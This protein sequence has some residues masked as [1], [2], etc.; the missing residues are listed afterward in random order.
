MQSK[1]NLPESHPLFRVVEALDSAQEIGQGVLRVS[2]DE[3][4]ENPGS[5]ER[6]LGAPALL[7]KVSPGRSAAVGQEQEEQ[8]GAEDPHFRH[9]AHKLCYTQN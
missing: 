5:E 7:R 8:R 9:G 4:N 6:R 1:F 3:R 2:A